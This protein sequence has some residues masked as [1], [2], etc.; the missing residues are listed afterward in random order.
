MDRAHR[1]LMGWP[2]E[3]NAVGGPDEGALLG[4]QRWQSPDVVGEPLV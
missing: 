3:L 1:D 4:L 2:A